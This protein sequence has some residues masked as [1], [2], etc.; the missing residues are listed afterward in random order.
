MM[1]ICVT[2]K[3]RYPLFRR[4]IAQL[5]ECRLDDAELVVADWSSTDCDV[6]GWLK[7]ALA[8]ANMDMTL[9]KLPGDVVFSRGEGLNR[10]AGVAQHDNLF[11]IDTDMLMAR[12]VFERAEEVLKAGGAYFPVCWSYT[13]PEQTKGR[14]RVNGKG[15]AAVT[16]KVWRAAGKWPEL[17]QWGSEDQMFHAA[18]AKLAPIVRENTKGLFHQWHTPSNSIRHGAC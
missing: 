12:S 10:A 8:H 18:V 1:S 5:V 4:C 11:F 9:V 15:I 3:N 2:V 14:W 17:H 13:N 6:A 7:Q 16:R